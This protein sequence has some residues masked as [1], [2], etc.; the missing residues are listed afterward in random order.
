MF[1]CH[2]LTFFFQKIL[3]GIQSER[4]AV[5]IQIRTDDLGPNFLQRKKVATN[6]VKNVF[7]AANCADPD[8]MLH[9]AKYRF[10]VYNKI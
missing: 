10:P 2:L 3:L 4:Q 7:T 9:F 6:E 5:W 1:Y 8:G